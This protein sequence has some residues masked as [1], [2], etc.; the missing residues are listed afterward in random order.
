MMAKVFNRNC[1]LYLLVIFLGLRVFTLSQEIIVLEQQVKTIQEESMQPMIIHEFFIVEEKE[2]AEFVMYSYEEIVDFDLTQPSN[3]TPD[4]LREVLKYNL[5]DYAET[6]IQAEEITGVNA[7]FLATLAAWE[8]GWGRVP[9]ENNNLFGFMDG[10]YYP[11]PEDS[12]VPTAEKIKTYYLSEGGKYHK[13]YT[14]DAVNYYYN[15]RDTWS[16]G[17]KEIMYCINRDIFLTFG[18]KHGII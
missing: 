17:M 6:F 10:D 15:G 11:T 2:A 3:L 4:Q 13:G 9:A 8:S 16:K 5:K 1:I 7:V 12:I 18:E 14:I